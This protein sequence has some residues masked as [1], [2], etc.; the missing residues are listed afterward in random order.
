M[1][2]LVSQVITAL[3]EPYVGLVTG[4]ANKLMVVAPND[5]A[6]TKF[7]ADAN[8]TLDALFAEADMTT[9]KSVID[10]HVFY[11]TSVT[12]QGANGV[13]NDIRSPL[14]GISRLI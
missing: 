14:L 12:V 7:V 6:F 4:T 11:D 9:L 8:T 5:A 1:R 2:W 13:R 10:Y 3:G